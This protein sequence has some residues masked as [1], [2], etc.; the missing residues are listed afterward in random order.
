[1][2]KVDV[3]RSR[4]KRVEEGRFG[5]HV[6]R[7]VRNTVLV[8]IAMSA[9]FVGGVPLA[10]GDGQVNS[11]CPECSQVP[12]LYHRDPHL[13]GGVGRQFRPQRRTGALQDEFSAKLQGHR[14]IDHPPPGVVQHGIAGC[15]YAP[16]VLPGGEKKE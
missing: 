5:G 1:M 8:G 16:M 11:G 13:Q 7:H 10:S 9:L 12:A 3:V 14:V 6:M 15:S 2:T 4:K